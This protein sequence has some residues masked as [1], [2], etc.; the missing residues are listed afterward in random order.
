MGGDAGQVDAAT[1]VL[2]DEQ[3]VEPA[4][5][6]VSTWKKSTAAIVLAWADRN[7]FQLADARRGAG[8]MPAAWRISQMVEGAILWPRPFSSPQIRR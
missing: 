2:D 7:C 8:S 4:Q 3:H 5:K 6:T 1:V